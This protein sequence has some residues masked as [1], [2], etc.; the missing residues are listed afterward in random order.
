M[1]GERVSGLRTVGDLRRHG[2]FKTVK[3]SQYAHLS[4]L[5]IVK[6]YEKKVNRI[7]ETLDA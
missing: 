4:M 2:D 3:L 1:R 7:S 6:S 5:Y